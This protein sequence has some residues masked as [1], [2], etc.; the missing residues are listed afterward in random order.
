MRKIFMIVVLIISASLVAEMTI[1]YRGPENEMDKRME[2]PLA[3]I[4]RALEVT[5]EEYGSFHLVPTP[6]MNA[7][8]AQSRDVAYKY[9]NYIV[10]ASV[11]KKLEEELLSIKI[12]T[13][14]GLFG[15]RLM[16]IDRDDQ[17]LFDTIYTLDQL[18]EIPL[19]QG[20]TWMDTKVLLDN[21]FN[22]IKG[23]NYEGLIKMLVNGRFKAFPRGINEAYK[24]VSIQ[25]RRYPRL[26]V[27]R[28]LCIYYPLVKFIYTAKKNIL[29]HERLTKGLM[30]M[31]DSGDFDR[32]WTK[33][34]YKYIEEAKLG[35]RII[36]P[37]NNRFLE[38][39]V[40]LDDDFFYR[41]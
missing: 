33:F 11:S 3:L 20:S 18:K 5:E 8:R 7:K 34:N 13:T 31:I 26:V 21:E 22:V 30:I 27:E 1:H 23:L 24:E 41:P 39:V 29:L 28:N 12:P 10:E 36:L 15:Y 19:G 4:N 35:S 17:E 2:Y 32:I 40:P 6:R 16:I 38:E 9:E 25:G 37:I 14:K